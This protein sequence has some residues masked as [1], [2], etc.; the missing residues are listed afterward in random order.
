MELALD[1][2]LKIREL[3]RAYFERGYVVKGFHRSEGG[4]FYRLEREETPAD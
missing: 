4:A 2:R 1:W 3:F